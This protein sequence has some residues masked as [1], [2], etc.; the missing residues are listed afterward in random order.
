MKEGTIVTTPLGE[1]FTMEIV[2]GFNKIF[3]SYDPKVVKLN[4]I[5]ILIK[6]GEDTIF[7]AISKYGSYGVEEGLWEIMPGHAPK[8]W[9]DRVLGHLTFKEVWKYILKEI[10]IVG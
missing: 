1:G 7:S 3:A 8:S 6:K 2:T 10:K 5:Q 4:D 9:N